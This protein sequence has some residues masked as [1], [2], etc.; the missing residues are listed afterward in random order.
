MSTNLECRERKR[1]RK[2]KVGD[3]L[4]ELNEKKSD[5]ELEARDKKQRRQISLEEQHGIP[6]ERN[7]KCEQTKGKNEA[8]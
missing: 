2:E 5:R 6:E 1:N 3:R 7:M 4:A 8:Q